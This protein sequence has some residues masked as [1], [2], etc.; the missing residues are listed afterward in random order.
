MLWCLLPASIT[1]LVLALFVLVSPPPR[2]PNVRRM[3]PL[4]F[5]RGCIALTFLLAALLMLLL[6]VAITQPTLLG[7]V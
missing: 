5:L 1:C 7:G 3:R 6:A 2:V 4:R